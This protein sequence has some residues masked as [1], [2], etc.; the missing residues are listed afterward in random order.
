MIYV[1]IRGNFGNQLF[2]YAFARSLQERFKQKICLNI[3]DLKHYRK[4]YV[5][6]LNGYKLNENVV[7]E[8]NKRMPYF[9]NLRK[10]FILRLCRKMFPQLTFNVLKRFG[11][12]IW[13]GKTVQSIPEKEHKNF[14]VDGYWQSDKYFNDIKTI[15]KK[16][17][18]NDRINEQNKEIEDKIIKT[19]SVCVSIRRG[20]YI[21]NKKYRKEFYICNEEYF[22]RAMKYIEKKV[23]DCTYFICSDDIEWAKERFKGKDNIFFESGKDDVFEKIRLMSKCKHFILSNSSFSWWAQYL[24]E[25]KNKIVVAPSQWYVNGEKTAIYQ[26]NWT[27]LE[28]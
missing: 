9:V 10:N 18:K 1:N 7:V 19:N 8:E 26:D 6:N 3:Y 27:L 24:A 13:L 22:R 23:P 2:E 20:D 12:F 15:I 14:Y 16:E 25:S 4:E 17:F 11:I 5:F 28:I 21:T